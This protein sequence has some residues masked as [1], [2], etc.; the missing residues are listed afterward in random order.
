MNIKNIKNCEKFSDIMDKTKGKITFEEKNFL[1]NHIKECNSC[2]FELNLSKLMIGNEDI[3]PLPPLDLE[4]EKNYINSIVE[5]SEQNQKKENLV[6]LF[7]DWLNINCRSKLVY[8]AASFLIIFSLIISYYLY[9]KEPQTN[10]QTHYL[11]Y[12]LSSGEKNSTIKTGDII[13]TDSEK[14]IVD[15]KNNSY[16]I[17]EKKSSIKINKLTENERQIILN[18]GKL[19][20]KINPYNHKTKLKIITPDGEIYVKGTVFSVEKNN[21]TKLTVFE[22][23]VAV[24]LKNQREILVSSSS[25]YNLTKMEYETF[26]S[27][28]YQSR[29]AIFNTI[30]N[31]GAPFTI[32]SL[33]Q[34]AEVRI[35]SDFIGKTPLNLKIKKGNHRLSIEYSGYKTYSENLE[36][37]N[38]EKIIKFITLSSV[39]FMDNGQNKIIKN[40]I[41]ENKQIKN[42]KIQ[43]EVKNTVKEITDVEKLQS[44]PEELLTQAHTFRIQ[45]QWD[46]AV[47]S[48]EDLISSNPDSGEAKIALIYLGELLLE[49]FNQPH[50]AVVH[51]DNYLKIS[52]QGS[53][54]SEAYMGEISAYQKLGNKVKE[55]EKIEEYLKRYP[56]SL[57]FIELQKR[58]EELR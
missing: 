33:P 10:I 51:F 5:L 35:D 20:A 30:S 13:L 8:T 21:E 25:C 2:K 36:I 40:N 17:I 34:G 47:N 16:L 26:N 46:K 37:A 31:D 6:K 4:N 43:P 9:I 12:I 19:L 32:N 50:K 15:L 54:V 24:K 18:K 39:S 58:L 14:V 42:I 49:Q 27:Q 22:G 23:T 38:L 56:A 28:N 7:I 11:S 1:E 55:R 52:P 29:I 44:T 48:Y 41:V 57:N 45:H 53:L 3:G